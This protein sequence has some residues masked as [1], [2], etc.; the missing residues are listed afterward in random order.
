MY[1]LALGVRLTD[2]LGT[3]LEFFGDVH[4]DGPGQQIRESAVH[5][6]AGPRSPRPTEMT[7][8][9]FIGTGPQHSMAAIGADKTTAT[10]QQTADHR[11]G[12][13]R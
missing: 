7:D 9:V 8:E 2:R 13:Q 5:G 12:G 1:S 10:L 3:F 6:L 4:L 11:H